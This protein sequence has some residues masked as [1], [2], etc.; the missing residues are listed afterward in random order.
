MSLKSLS[1][2]EA[3]DWQSFPQ[4]LIAF[5]VAKPE[6]DLAKRE[7]ANFQAL[8]EELNQ[9]KIQI[10]FVTNQGEASASEVDYWLDEARE[11][12]NLA[13]PI[14]KQKTLSENVI[15]YKK[16]GEQLQYLV[17]KELP[18]AEYN[19]VEVI[20][21]FG[22]NYQNTE[23]DSRNLWRWG[24]I[25]QE[26]GEYLCV[27]C[28]YILELEAGAVFPVCEVCLSGEP[29]GPATPETGYWEKI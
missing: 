7:I 11:Y 8:S 23:P 14:S 27:D 24:Q 26:T 6:S 19:W 22:L 21:Q 2:N 18:E 12:I 17:H 13:E 4:E 28:G 3:I 10:F 25:V 29:S 15:I 16:T 1:N 5:I 20:K 9:A